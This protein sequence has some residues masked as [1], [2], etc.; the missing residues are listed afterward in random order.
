MTRSADIPVADHPWAQPAASSAASHSS[1]AVAHSAAT[2]CVGV[3]VRRFFPQEPRELAVRMHGN[4]VQVTSE[5]KGSSRYTFDHCFWSSDVSDTDMP[6]ATQEDVFSCLGRP[7]LRQLTEGYNCS[8]IAYGP[9]GSGKTYS[10]FGPNSDSSTVVAG[11]GHSQVESSGDADSADASPATTSCSFSADDGADGRKSEVGIIPRIVRSLFRVAGSRI[12]RATCSIVEIYLDDVFDLLAEGKPTVVVKSDPVKKTY[13][14]QGAVEATVRSFDDMERLLDESS[15]R[16]TI[17]STARNIHSSRAHTLVQLTIDFFLPE[18][19]TVRLAF[20]DLAGSERAKESKASGVVLEQAKHINLSLLALGKCVEAAARIGREGTTNE[21]MHFKDCTLT[22]LLKEYIGGNTLTTLLVTIA[23]GPADYQHTIHALRFGDRAKHITNHASINTVLPEAVAAPNVLVGVANVG[24]VEMGVGDGGA[25][26][27]GG[28]VYLFRQTKEYV[29]AQ[30]TIRILSMLK[31]EH[32]L[33]TSIGV[34]EHAAY[35]ALLRYINR[36]IS[37]ANAQTL[38][39]ELNRLPILMRLKRAMQVADH[40]DAAPSQHHHDVHSAPPVLDEATSSEQQKGPAL[41]RLNFQRHLPARALSEDPTVNRNDKVSDGAA[42]QLPTV[43][44]APR[45]PPL[46]ERLLQLATPRP[47]QPTPRKR[48]SSGGEPPQESSSTPSK[49]ATGVGAAKR[50]AIKQSAAVTPSP[51]SKQSSSASLSAGLSA[52]PRKRT[53][54]DSASASPKSLSTRNMS[55]ADLIRKGG[56]AAKQARLLAERQL[57]AEEY[58]KRIV[59]DT[60]QGGAW[61]KMLKQVASD[62]PM[63]GAHNSEKERSEQHRQSVANLLSR[64]SSSAAVRRDGAAR[65]E[66]AITP[67]SSGDTTPRVAAIGT[68]NA[69]G[70]SPSFANISDSVQRSLVSPA[71][72]DDADRVIDMENGSGWVLRANPRTSRVQ[73]AKLRAPLPQTIPG[74]SSRTKQPSPP[75]QGRPESTYARPLSLDGL[76]DAE[77]RARAEM[78]EE[79]SRDMRYFLAVCA[80]DAA[81]CV[82]DVTES[83]MAE[84][85]RSRSRVPNALLQLLSDFQKELDSG[86]ERSE[87]WSLVAAASD[88]DEEALLAHSLASLAKISW[89]WLFRWLEY[90]SRV[91]LWIREAET[92]DLSIHQF[93]TKLAARR[94][95]LSQYSAFEEP[96]LTSNRL[97][98]AIEDDASIL[99][100]EMARGINVLRNLALTPADLRYELEMSLS[101]Q[102]VSKNG[103]LLPSTVALGRGSDRQ[104]LAESSDASQGLHRPRQRRFVSFTDDASEQMPRRASV[105]AI[106]VSTPIQDTPPSTPSNSPHSSVSSTPRSTPSRTPSPT[107]P[108]ADSSTDGYR[109][110]HD[111]ALHDQPSFYPLPCDSSAATTVYYVLR[112]VDVIESCKSNITSQNSRGTFTDEE[113]KRVTKSEEEMDRVKRDMASALRDE[114]RRILLSD[115]QGQRDDEAAKER[116]EEFFSDLVF[117]TDINPVNLLVVR[118]VLDAW[119]QGRFPDSPNFVQLSESRGLIAAACTDGSIGYLRS[120]LNLYRT[121]T[122]SAPS[123]GIVEG[124]APVCGNLDFE[125]VCCSAMFNQLHRIPLVNA[126]LDYVLDGKLYPTL[127]ASFAESAS[128]LRHQWNEFCSD[129]ASAKKCIP[130]ENRKERD[131]LLQRILCSSTVIPIDPFDEGADDQTRVSRVCKDGDAAALGVFLNALPKETIR[132]LLLK[133]QADSTTCLIQCVLGG[134]VDCCRAVTSALKEILLLSSEHTSEITRVLHHRCSEGS[135][136][137]LCR[138]LKRDAAI[139]RELVSLERALTA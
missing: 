62:I 88:A 10:L 83:H 119:R 110:D 133:I 138:M 30:R 64:R 137:E 118:A 139:E 5:E 31:R 59:I 94:G 117:A 4:T 84:H 95:S 63:H 96:E 76:T 85:P 127:S 128:G 107:T 101:P 1:S 39:Q 35:A 89:V 33:R 68:Q 13:T 50:V 93:A 129:I 2:L 116:F 53:D 44:H 106:S 115:A 113:L 82:Q 37:R 90:T 104:V 92:F 8:L 58:M 27:H 91:L 6:H 75:L 54:S 81:L 111:M 24:N 29:A 108:A 103:I 17:K 65:V 77:A 26:G 67:C 55:D 15:R 78:E 74:P 86:S 124:E 9:T 99:Q 114:S 32:H 136:L 21:V 132:E 98:A 36:E 120:L 61:K 73:S 48:G 49:A 69:A 12:S 97:L 43:A 79:E 56:N 11:R 71:V 80:V 52:T 3:R 130:K 66:S 16:K 121:P 102:D 20:A 23:P 45:P 60:E 57:T 38:R 19:R 109:Q 135:A 105:A 112:D 126:L 51:S 70:V 22:K 123:A 40:R 14:L 122:F 87:H 25:G 47:A 18:K 42:T 125:E 100:L 34:A 46:S 131:V 7:I 41:P 134:S 72:S 28:R